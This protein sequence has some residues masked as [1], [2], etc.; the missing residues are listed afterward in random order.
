ML[1]LTIAET[2]KHDYSDVYLLTVEM[3]D[4]G[5]TIDTVFFYLQEGYDENNNSCTAKTIEAL[6]EL[7]CVGTDPTGHP[8]IPRILA[9]ELGSR[10][11]QRAPCGT[12]YCTPKL[13]S[14]SYLDE[15]GQEFPVTWSRI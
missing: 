15:Y 2:P 13:I 7:V 1:D 14:V 3:Q 5:T 6:E 8:V 12:H 4:A 10:F 9:E 11:V